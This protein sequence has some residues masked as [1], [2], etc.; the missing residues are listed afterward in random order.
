MIQFL[1]SKDYN[2]NILTLVWLSILYLQTCPSLRY[3][4]RRCF[5]FAIF[6]DMG[7]KSSDNYR[8]LENASYLH[9]DIH[10]CH[11]VAVLGHV[12]VS[13]LMWESKLTTRR[14]SMNRALNLLK[15]ENVV[16]AW[17]SH[18][19]QTTTNTQKTL[20]SWY[21]KLKWRVLH[22]ARYAVVY[23]VT[24]VQSIKQE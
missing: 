18:S 23:V 3:R 15:W 20:L 24:A 10:I 11:N 1:K 22:A 12:I 4:N 17:I 7:E 2:P 14:L 13:L 9:R 6:S 8:W 16:K 5:L 19:V 21:L